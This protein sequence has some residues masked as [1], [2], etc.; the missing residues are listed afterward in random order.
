[1]RE[2]AFHLKGAVPH[3]TCYKV[4]GAEA[5]GRRMMADRRR[6]SSPMALVSSREGVGEV[7]RDE[8]RQGRAEVSLI[9]NA[10]DEVQ[11]I[12]TPGE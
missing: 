9:V 1:M 7:R 4:D 2:S 8:T 6:V 3:S 11:V 10:G 5:D 12:R